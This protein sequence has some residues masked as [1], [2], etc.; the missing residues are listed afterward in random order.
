MRRAAFP[1]LCLLLLFA[2]CEKPE[3]VSIQVGTQRVAVI[4]PPDWEHF[5]YG[6]QHQ[7]RR[8][9]ERISLQ[10]MGRMGGNID[11]VVER[12]LEMLGEDE[13]REIA[14]RDTLQVS[15]RD[16]RMIETWDVVSHQYR[17]RFL[18][19]INE[20]ELLGLY[21]QQGQFELM[22]PAFTEMAGSMAFIDTTGGGGDKAQ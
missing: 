8:D 16:A 1:Y 12:A 20:R 13:R 5:D 15:G 4:H 3:P 9:F 6:E 19:V 14:F 21:T 17:K 7:W 2:A 10:D 18:F 22:E 11:G